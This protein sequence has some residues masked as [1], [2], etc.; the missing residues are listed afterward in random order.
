MSMKLSVPPSPV[1]YLRRRSF[2]YREGA[3]ERENLPDQWSSFVRSCCRCLQKHG[4]MSQV[5]VSLGEI[6]RTV[7]ERLSSQPL[8]RFHPHRDT[9]FSTDFYC[10]GVRYDKMK[11]LK[12]Q[13][14]SSIPMFSYRLDRTLSWCPQNMMGSGK[15]SSEF[16]QG[17]SLKLVLILKLYYFMSGFIMNF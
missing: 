4:D 17:C 16:P 14:F 12:R 10:Y 15:Q 1:F 3:R 8:Q 2:I 5:Y 9:D 11:L 7:V 6:N 13:V